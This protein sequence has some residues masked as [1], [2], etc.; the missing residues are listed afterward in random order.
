MTCDKSRAP[1]S[2]ADIHVHGILQ[3]C[4]EI[5]SAEVNNHIGASIHRQGLQ[6]PWDV[7]FQKEGFILF[8]IYDLF[9]SDGEWG[10]FYNEGLP[11]L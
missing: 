5:K 3:P 6:F 10:N 9:L 1:L 8:R 11:S 7:T 2:P 4:H